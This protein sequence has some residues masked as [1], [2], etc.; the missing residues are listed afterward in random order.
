MNF[1]DL[2]K[3]LRHW[4]QINMSY[5]LYFA[6]SC[7]LSTDPLTNAVDCINHMLN[8]VN[9]LICR[10]NVVRPNYVQQ[11]DFRSI[12]TRNE[13]MSLIMLKFVTDLVHCH[14]MGC[15]RSC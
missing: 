4:Y 8:Y 7:Y 2:K 11:I 5:T 13:Y 15:E 3:I 9:Y 12:P 14:G 6:F 1:L 10:F